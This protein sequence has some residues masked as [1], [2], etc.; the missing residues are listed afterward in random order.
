VFP[1]DDLRA[2]F[3]LFV[4]ERALDPRISWKFEDDEGYPAG[5]HVLEVLE[6]HRDLVRF[7]L[8]QVDDEEDRPH[9]FEPGWPVA[10]RSL[11]DALLAFLI[12]LLSKAG[13]ERYL[14]DYATWL[15]TVVLVVADAQRDPSCLTISFPLNE[16]GDPDRSIPP[17]HREERTMTL[18]GTWGCLSRDTYKL[19]RRAARRLG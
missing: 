17:H 6:A 19:I 8:T 11:Q 7:Y 13:L 4:Y 10:Y 18:D 5:S 3:W 2:E 1:E 16:Y 9:E 14:Y 15:R 12:E